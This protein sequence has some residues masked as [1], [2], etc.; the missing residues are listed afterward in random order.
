MSCAE[1]VEPFWDDYWSGYVYNE[2]D[3]VHKQG[4]EWTDCVRWILEQ[5]QAYLDGHIRRDRLRKDYK[6]VIWYADALVTETENRCPQVYVATTAGLA[7]YTA[8]MDEDFDPS[9]IAPNLSDR[10]I[11]SDYLD[12]GFFAVKVYAECAS[13][14]STVEERWREF[15]RIYVDELTPS[16]Y[17]A[18][19]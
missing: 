9:S 11:D 17:R 4:P 12:A 7:A 5:A 15:W 1:L 8:A 13:T 18:V 16:V 2:E 3:D 6:E 14:P 19:P 10:D